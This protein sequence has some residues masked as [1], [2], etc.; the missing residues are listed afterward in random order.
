MSDL[1]Y[2]NACFFKKNCLLSN[3]CLRFAPLKVLVYLRNFFFARDL[4][5]RL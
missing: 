3:F 5:L 4:F 2:F 1:N